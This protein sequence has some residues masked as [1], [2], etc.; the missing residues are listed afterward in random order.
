[1][2]FSKS[3][4]FSMKVRLTFFLLSS[5]FHPIENIP[6][7]TNSNK[8]IKSMRTT[9]IMVKLWHSTSKSTHS[10]IYKNTNLI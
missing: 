4:E 7:S 10:I 9:S 2:K 5:N 8:Y 6:F 3:D 1:M